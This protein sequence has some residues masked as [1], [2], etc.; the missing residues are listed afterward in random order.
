D[1]EQPLVVGQ[2]V[3]GARLVALHREQRA[4]GRAVGQR[5]LEPSRNLGD[6][7]LDEPEVADRKSTRLNSSHVSISYA[8]FCLKKKKL[9][10]YIE[11]TRQF[12]PNNSQLHESLA[13]LVRRRGQFDRTAC[14]FNE[15]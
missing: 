13:Y 11:Q 10:L 14:C 15:P 9:L 6:Q 2:E 5:M 1:E 3:A 4:P 7:V 8:V 12:L